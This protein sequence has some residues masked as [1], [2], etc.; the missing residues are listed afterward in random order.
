[1]MF[2]CCSHS[3][4]KFSVQ[5]FK[6]WRLGSL[7]NAARMIFLLGSLKLLETWTGTKLWRAAKAFG[8]TCRSTHHATYKILFA[9]CFFTLASRV[10]RN[11]R[12]AWLRASR[13]RTLLFLLR[14]FK[15]G[16][17]PPATTT[18]ASSLFL[19]KEF[20]T[21]HWSDSHQKWDK[22]IFEKQWF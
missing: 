17:K 14:F 10:K 16:T 8:T 13:C 18:I 7:S 6:T 9:H 20:Q 4:I 22:C 1:M 15:Q 5:D 3:F 21:Y 11:L 2:A 19:W 12:N